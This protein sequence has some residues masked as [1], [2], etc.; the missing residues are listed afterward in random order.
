MP[1]EKIKQLVE[2]MVKNIVDNPDSVIVA[3]SEVSKV[4]VINIKPHPEDIGKVIGKSGKN[5]DAIRVIM[6]AAAMANQDRRKYHLEVDTG[7]P[8][9]Y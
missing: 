2:D 8:R 9:D 1:A 6:M 7:A 5:V 3:L 4:V